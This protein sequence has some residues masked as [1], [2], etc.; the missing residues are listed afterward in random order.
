VSALRGRLQTLALAVVV[1]ALCWLAAEWVVARL[2]LLEAPPA[3]SMGHARRGY[4]LRPG[5]DGVTK[6]G[7]RIRISSLGLRSPE[8]TAA[9]P[10]GTLRLLVL[11]DSVTFGWGVDEEVTFARRIE[12]ALRAE[13]PCPVEVLNAGVSGYGSIEEADFFA[14]EGLAL[15]PDALLVYQ[16]ENDNELAKPVRGR[17]ITFLKD[18]VAYRSH[19]VNAMLYGWRVTRWRLQAMRAGGDAVAYEAQ[20]RAWGSKPG[21][22]ESLDALRRIGAL[23]RERGIPVVLGSNPTRIDDPSIDAERTR[24]L[25]AMAAESGMRFVEI[26]PAFAHRDP[27]TLAVSETDRHP[28]ALG[29]QLIAETLLP[30]VRAAV[31]CPTAEP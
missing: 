9:K 7:V 5:F 13:L 14:H 23:A 30:A 11:G 2:Q 4:Q 31:R 25:R 6:H 16:V 10:P 21:A 18:W 3:M 27:D 12:R 28:N 26:A 8:V 24:L 17:V 1:G 22:P 20:Q 19:L 29:H 15:E